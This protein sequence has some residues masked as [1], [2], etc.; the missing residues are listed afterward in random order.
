MNA[1]RMTAKAEALGEA[2]AER[3]RDQ[4]VVADLPQGVR[5]EKTAQC[6]CLVGENLRRRMLEDARIRNF[7][8]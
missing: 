4:L 3:L 2:R 1:D 8:R 6:V 5:I 7:G